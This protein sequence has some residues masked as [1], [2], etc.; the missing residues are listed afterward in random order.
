MLA[1]LRLRLWSTLACAII[2]VLT[3][4]LPAGSLLA[5]SPVMVAQ[6]MREFDILID[7]KP[8]GQSRMLISEYEDGHASVV[9]AGKIRLN[10]ILFTFEYELRETEV[11]HGENFLRAE[12]EVNNNGTKSK[13]TLKTNK[14][15]SKISKDGKEAT[16]PT[17]S[18]SNNYWR[19]PG[20]AHLSKKV[21]V[22]E[23]ETG[24]AKVCTLERGE[25]SSLTIQ[26][27][28]LACR[29]YHL[30]GDLQVEFAFDDQ[31][32]LAYQKTK[33]LGRLAE[34][35]LKSIKPIEVTVAER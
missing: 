18:F 27:E 5:A 26:G 31:G 24:D 13:V 4:I 21:H 11:W 1:S 7:G 22:L 15:G 19:V 9:T 29:R 32:R 16:G 23:S 12:T 33:K 17:F 8:C 35:K 34:L 10:L 30:K 20:D 6:Q 2:A 3:L 28:K 14:G 25:P